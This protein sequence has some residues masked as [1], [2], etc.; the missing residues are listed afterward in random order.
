[1]KPKLFLHIC[2]IGCGAYIAQ[3][4][5][6][7]YDIELFF[8]NP[9]I[10]PLEEYEKRLEEIRKVARAEELEVSVG[11]YDHDA[12]LKLVRGHELDPER[13]ERCR[14]CYAKRLAETAREAKERG[15]DH[16]AST[17]SISP[18]KDARALSEIGNKLATLYGVKFFDRDFKK[19]D[20]FKKS[21]QLSREL[22]L[23]RQTYCGCEFS[24]RH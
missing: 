5:K 16:F 23:Y 21:C 6:K 12:W 17:L 13:G 14:I 2:C 7:D 20:G 11:D 18:H 8:F 19:G 3:D 4:L 15:F 24:M 9:N 1:M 22:G 10:F